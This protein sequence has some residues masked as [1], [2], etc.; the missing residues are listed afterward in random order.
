M[1]TVLFETTGQSV[2]IQVDKGTKTVRV[3]S[4]VTGYEFVNKSWSYLFDKGIFWADTPKGVNLKKIPLKI[5]DLKRNFLLRQSHQLNLFQVHNI[6]KENDTNWKKEMEEA[7]QLT[8]DQ[9]KKKIIKNMELIGYKYV[10]KKNE[11]STSNAK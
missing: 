9:L 4:H 2:F 3:K 8:E 11:R 5:K 7:E 1:F 10:K 6:E